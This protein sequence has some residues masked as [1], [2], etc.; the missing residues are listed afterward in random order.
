[1]R[2]PRHL[3]EIRRGQK[4]GD[5][6]SCHAFSL[7]HANV[8]GVGGESAGSTACRL[9]LRQSGKGAVG[10]SRAKIESKGG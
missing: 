8:H 3:G 2:E 10:F 1:M 7:S 9:C 5:A 6:P 4:S